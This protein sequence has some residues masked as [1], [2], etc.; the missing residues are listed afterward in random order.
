HVVPRQVEGADGRTSAE[1]ERDLRDQVTVACK[2]VGC[3]SFL[4]VKDEVVDAGSADGEILDRI[5]RGRIDLVVL[6]THG[7]SARSRAQI[8]S[9]SSSVAREADCPVLLVPP[10]MWKMRRSREASVWRQIPTD[11]G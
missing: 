11:T 3:G 9:V 10:A 4:E 1:A 8:G 6:G 2:R 7:E 5:R